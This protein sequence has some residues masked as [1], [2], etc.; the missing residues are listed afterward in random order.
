M[1]YTTNYQLPVWAETDRILRTDFNDLTDKIE[2]A[3]GALQGD[4]DANTAGL[5]TASTELNTKGNCQTFLTAYVGTGNVQ[6]G[7]QLV[8]PNKPF[9]AFLL[10]V[11]TGQCYPLPYGATQTQGS[12]GTPMYGISWSGNVLTL[13]TSVQQTAANEAGRSYHLFVLLERQ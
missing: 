9:L 13:P 12:L 1:D 10:D 11:Y 2:E 7:R 5:S 3:L 6:G 4:V 8:F